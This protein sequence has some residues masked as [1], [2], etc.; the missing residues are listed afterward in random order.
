MWKEGNTKDFQTTR[1]GRKEARS[2]REVRNV[3]GR[4]RMMVCEIGSGEEECIEEE[5]WQ[6]GEAEEAS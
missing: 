5:G 1:E 2:E 6:A 4:G 3:Q